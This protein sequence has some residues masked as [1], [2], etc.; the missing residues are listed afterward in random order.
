MKFKEVAHLYIGCKIQAG[1][2]EFSRPTLTHCQNSSEE[3]A[4]RFAVDVP[5]Y[6]PILRRIESLNELE[7]RQACTIMQLKGGIFGAAECIV[8]LT[9]KHID[10][11][12]LI[13]SGE[14]IDA[15]TLNP[16]PYL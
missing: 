9:S 1:R 14:A 12:G 6:K 8:F 15:S 16:N 11:F 10:C 2:T 7:D 5:A 3:I 4:I 13:E